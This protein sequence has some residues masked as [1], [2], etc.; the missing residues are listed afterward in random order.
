MNENPHPLQAELHRLLRDT[1]ALE[2]GTFLQP[3]GMTGS[4]LHPRRLTL[5]PKGA[6]TVAQMVLERLRP[7]NV[8]FVCGAG[9]GGIALAAQTALASALDINGPPIRAFYH[10]TEVKAHGAHTSLEG[11]QPS[12]GA[13]TAV[14]TD[15]LETG[16][17]L[18]Q[19]AQAAEDCGADIVLMLAIIGRDK[20]G[21]ENLKRAG[22]HTETLCEAP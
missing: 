15:L 8:T 5:H 7:E 22:Y 1:G 16:E 3:S 11:R 14:I 6:L 17:T 12:K 21:Q 19:A 13:R 18:L 10:R 2:E 9:E 4:R 20:G